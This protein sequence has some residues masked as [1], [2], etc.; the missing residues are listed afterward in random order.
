MRLDI[1]GPGCQKKK[2]SR[3]QGGQVRQV[4]QPPRFPIIAYEQPSRQSR[5]WHERRVRF[6]K[7]ANFLPICTVPERQRG[8]GGKRNLLKRGTNNHQP[9]QTDAESVLSAEMEKVVYKP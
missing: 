1:L 5:K 4:L 9:D 3:V 7:V 6:H 8:G 2:G